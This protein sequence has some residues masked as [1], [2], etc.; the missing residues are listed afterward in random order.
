M[1]SGQL[2]WTEK[3]GWRCELRVGP[4]GINRLE[5][6]KGEQLVTTEATVPGRLASYRSEFL[7]QRVVR[8]DLRTSD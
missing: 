8:G 4:A 7:R 5:V 2:L 6:Y 3:D 1:V